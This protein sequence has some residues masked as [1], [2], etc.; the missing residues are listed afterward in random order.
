[1]GMPIAHELKTQHQGGS[2]KGKLL[3]VDDDVNDCERYVKPILRAGGG[4]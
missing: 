4:V 1:M 2:W 3:L